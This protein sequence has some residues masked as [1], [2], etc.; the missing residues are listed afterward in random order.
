ML[1]TSELPHLRWTKKNVGVC[2]EESLD[3]TPQKF[4]VNE[5]KTKKHSRIYSMQLDCFHPDW[6]VKLSHPAWPAVSGQLKALLKHAKLG[7]RIWGSPHQARL[8]LCL[9]LL[10][11][12]RRA[13]VRVNRV[14]KYFKSP[15][16]TPFFNIKQSDC[17][18]YLIDLLMC[19]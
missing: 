6:E 19:W 10:G 13:R 4:N 1:K 2:S 7:I 17:N 15:P 9:P 5:H 3:F 16:F 14:S 18:F 11:I 8:S 12:Y